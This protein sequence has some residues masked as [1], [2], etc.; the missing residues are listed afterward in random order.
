MKT[1]NYI[2]KDFLILSFIALGKN[3]DDW[4]HALLSTSGTV[5][6]SGSTM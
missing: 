5:A 2:L 1:I 6:P 4:G 3:G